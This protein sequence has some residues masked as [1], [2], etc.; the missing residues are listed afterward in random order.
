VEIVRL[1]D[2]LNRMPTQMHRSLWPK[3]LAKTQMSLAWRA[4]YRFDMK[5]ILEIYEVSASTFYEGEFDCG[6][7]NGNNKVYAWSR[8]CACLQVAMNKVREI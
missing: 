5:L 3:S 1:E 4:N 2:V 8:T 7:E 6:A